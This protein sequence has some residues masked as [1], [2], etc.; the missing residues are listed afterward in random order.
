MGNIQSR[1]NSTVSIALPNINLQEFYY[2]THFAIYYRIYIS[3]RTELGTI[4]LS[5]STLSGINPALSSD[6]FAIYPYT[7]TNTQNSQVN[8]SISAF[9]RN[10]NYYTLAL[11]NADIENDILASSSLGRTLE[12]DFAPMQTGRRYP[13]LSIN[14]QTYN[15]FRSNNNG[16]F[17]PLPDR[18]FVNTSQLYDRQNATSAINADVADN[19]IPL[20]I[21]TYVSM[22]I[23]VSGI[24]SNFSPINSIPTFIG[25][26]S[27]PG[28]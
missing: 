13:F 9:F 27:L 4:Q 1:L 23:V 12:I 17:N 18:Y 2:F 16:G 19:N 20:S 5:Q 15:L 8:T 10:R 24:D 11:E 22:Y 7:T 6:Y 28:F 21:H 3:D 25:I 14:G 26:F